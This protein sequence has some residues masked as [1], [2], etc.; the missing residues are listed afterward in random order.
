MPRSRS[1]RAHERARGIALAGASW[2]L[3]LV[4]A[5]CLLLT[6]WGLLIGARP[7]VI[8]TGS[9]APAMPVGT[10]VLVRPQPATDVTVGEVVAIRRSDGRRIMHR[11]RRARPAG[12]GSMT[13]VLRGDRNRAA[14]PAV[15]VRSVERPVLVVPAVGRPLTWLGGRWV[16]YWLGVATGLL[17]LAWVAIRR[18]RDAPE[19]PGRARRRRGPLH[20]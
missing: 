6:A 12:D 2:L 19:Q 17:A 20:A 4:G 7:L 9:M 15:T 13:L 16:Q 11:V 3:A 10:V 8:R 1:P 14:D 18:R 5:A